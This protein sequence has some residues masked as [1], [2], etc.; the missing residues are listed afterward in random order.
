[1]AGQSATFL[2]LPGV[3]KML[4]LMT[5]KEKELFTLLLDH[6]GDWFN[7]DKLPFLL[8]YSSKHSMMVANSGFTNMVGRGWIESKRDGQTTSFRTNMRGKMGGS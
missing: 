3:K 4:N 6:D 1:M 8:G 7:T 5:K 2:N